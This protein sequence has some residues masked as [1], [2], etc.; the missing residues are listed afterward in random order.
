MPIEQRIEGKKIQ[1][2]CRIHWRHHGDETA[3]RG[4]G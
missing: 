3:L 4:A 2:A 1:S